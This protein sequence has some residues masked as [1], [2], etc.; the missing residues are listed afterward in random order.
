M[1]KSKAKHS[2]ADK[3]AAIEAEK[4]VARAKRAAKNNKLKE[5]E[6]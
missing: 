1:A 4:P 3:K 6:E 5:A 2:K